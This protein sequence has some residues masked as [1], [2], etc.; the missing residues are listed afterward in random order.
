MAHFYKTDTGWR[1]Q[2]DKLGTRLSK[3]FRTKTEASYWAGVTEAEIVEGKKKG[4]PNKTVTA[5]LQKYMDEVSSGKRGFKWER[6]RIG[7]L[8]RDEL[9]KVK[10]GDLDRDDIGKWRDRRLKEVSAATV[11]REWN[12]LSHAFN[13]ALREW[14]WITENPMTGVRKPAPPP[15][16]DR[17]PTAQEIAALRHV[18]GDNVTT[19]TG[20]LGLM[21]EFAIETGMRAG[22]MSA[23]R[24][25]DVR[26]RVARIGQSKNGSARDVPLSQKAKEIIEHLPK[27]ADTVFNISTRNIDA[28]FRKAKKK[29]LVDGLHFH[30][31]RAEAI[32]RLAK[33]L[34][35]LDLARMVGHRDLKSLQVYYRESPEQIA[36]KLDL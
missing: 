6:D 24:W 16:R 31:L 27:D 33:K 1:A 32:T 5:L 35:I 26:G 4:Q 30:D 2:V 14:R 25:Q 19:E 10:L 3:V 15:A 11:R 12:L 21:V 20:R 22:E 34:D 17:L 9:A 23:L 13:V 36:D 8:M 29:A 18:L 7:L 28:L